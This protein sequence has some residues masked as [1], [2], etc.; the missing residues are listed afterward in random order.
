MQGYEDEQGLQYHEKP[1]H[2]DSAI[3]GSI[4][5]TVTQLQGQQREA[6]DAQQEARDR[7]V[8][9]RARLGQAEDEVA[10]LKR[11]LF[12]SQD[13][14][15]EAQENA[16]EKE[17]AYHETL[18]LLKRAQPGTPNATNQ[19]EWAL[20]Q[21]LEQQLNDANQQ[22]RQLREERAPD[23]GRWADPNAADGHGCSIVPD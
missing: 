2:L 11:D 19:V 23:A 20:I 17:K 12:G 5:A 4:I 9:A 22:L 3:A 8:D 16:R 10:Q 21:S 7:E 6:K 18:V 14:M 13:A 1:V 15:C